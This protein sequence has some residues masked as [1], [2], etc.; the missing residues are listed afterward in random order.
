MAE[1]SAVRYEVTGGVAHLVLDRPAQK[2]PLGPDEWRALRHGCARAEDDPVVR[3]LVIR[4]EGGVFSAGGDLRTMPERLAQPVA[5]RRRRLAHDARVIR[6][7]R[8]LGKPVVALCDGPAIGAGLNLALACDLRLASTRARFSASF[9]KVGLSSDFGGVYLLPEIV[10]VSRALELLLL[11]EP[12]TAEEA[13]RVGLVHRVFGEADF[14]TA[15]AEI[16]NKLCALPP[17]AVELTKQGVYRSTRIDL[18][19]AIEQEAAAQA[20]ISKTD[21]AKE[22]VQAFLDKR[23]PQFTGS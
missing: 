20:I 16:I 7:L 17:L 8:E 9:H 15:A 6:D 18:A 11:G 23:T 12:L 13:L 22:G 4:G 21:D 3:V 10:G 1:A 2:N 14:A 19:S 5:T